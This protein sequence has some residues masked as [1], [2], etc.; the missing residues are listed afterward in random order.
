M[1]SLRVSP[2][3]MLLEPEAK[4]A[5]RIPRYHAACSKETRVRVEFSKNS[6]P[7]VLLAQ[8]FGNVS[9]PRSRGP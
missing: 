5:L 1:V 2:L 7:T 9:C 3:L 6:I 8:G 4:L